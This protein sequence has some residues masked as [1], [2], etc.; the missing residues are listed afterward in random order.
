[1]SRPTA[2]TIPSVTVRSSPNGLPMATTVS[3]T[4]TRAE[5]ASASGSVPLGMRSAAMRTTARSLD[6]SLPRTRPA[7]ASPFSPKWTVT[8]RLS[9]TTWALVTIV[10]SPS[11]RNPVPA[12]D[13]ARMDTTAGLAAA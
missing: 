1:M 3:P 7:T 4:P 9:P 5:S 13:P 11:M 8:A 2:D 10:P 6:G 12:P